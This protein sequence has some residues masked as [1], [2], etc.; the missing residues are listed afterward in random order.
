VELDGQIIGKTPLSIEQDLIDKNKLGERI[1]TFYLYDYATLNQ[2]IQLYPSLNPLEINVDLIKL[3]GTFKNDKDAKG[4]ESKAKREAH[5]KAREIAIAEAAKVKAQKEAEEKAAKEAMEKARQ[6]AIAK[7]V[8]EKARVEAEAKAK[9]LAEE[10]ARRDAV[11]KIIA[12]KA[13]KEAEEAA[14][15]AKPVD[16]RVRER[17]EKMLKEGLKEEYVLLR[18]Y[19]AALEGY[20]TKYYGYINFGDGNENLSKEEFIEYSKYFKIA[21]MM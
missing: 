6:E 18:P 10:Q 7:A 5:K 20:V 3:E 16:Q 8:A 1:L 4:A 9:A 13:A 2:T 14:E 17:I 15:R 12:D 19:Q 11:A 21:K